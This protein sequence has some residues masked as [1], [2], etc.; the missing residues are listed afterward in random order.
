M[1]RHLNSFSVSGVR[2]LNKNCPK[3]Q[4]PGGLPGG[5]CLSFDF[6]GTLL[7]FIT[8]FTVNSSQL[9]QSIRTEYFKTKYWQSYSF[10]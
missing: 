9:N 5:G 6:T 3:I 7:S 2:N 1:M 8:P 10:D 4:M